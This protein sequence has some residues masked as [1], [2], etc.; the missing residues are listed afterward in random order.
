[1]HLFK[2]KH[3]L[4][5]IA[6]K[7]ADTKIA[8]KVDDMSVDDQDDE[9]DPVIDPEEVLAN[10]I[11]DTVEYLIRHDKDEIKKLL[12]KFLDSDENHEDDVVSLWQLVETWIEKQVATEVGIPTEDI[13]RILRKLVRSSSIPRSQV[14]C[15][16]LNYF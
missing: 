1:M 9:M 5:K 8:E 10:K 15:L 2:R 6:E 7:V 12:K 3:G 16:D 11:K 4:K 13:E 14:N